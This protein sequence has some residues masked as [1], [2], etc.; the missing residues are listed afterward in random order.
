MAGSIWAVSTPRRTGH[1]L[2]TAA[3]PLA[4]GPVDG[5]RGTRR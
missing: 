2:S 4:D 5:E 1:P 3:E